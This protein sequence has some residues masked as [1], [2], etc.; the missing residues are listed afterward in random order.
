MLLAAM[1][2]AVFAHAAPAAASVGTNDYP[3]ANQTKDSALSPL[4][5]Y[6]RECTDYAAWE[7][8]E[9]MGGDTTHILFKWANIESGGSGNA[10]NWK[11]GA[12]N[13]YGANSVNATP[14]VG[15]VAW[16]NSGDWT[17]DSAGHVAIV[18]QVDYNTNG[19]VKDIVVADYNGDNQGNYGSHTINASGSPGYLVWPNNFLHIADVSGGGSTLPPAHAVPAASAYGTDFYVVA[20]GQDGTMYRNYWN[21]SSWSG[22]AGIAPNDVYNT[23][24]VVASAGGL[25]WVIGRG[26]DGNLYANNWNG[27]SWSGFGDIAPGNVFTHD[28]VAAAYGSGLMVVARGQDGTMYRNYWNGTSWSGSASIAPNNVFD[29][30]PVV[31]TAG[32][33]FWVVA[34]G[35]DGNIYANAWNG[36]SWTG[37]MNTA[38]GHV[39]DDSPVA[40]AYGSGT[41]IVARGQDGNL[42]TN[43]WNGSSWGGFVDIAPGNVFP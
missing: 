34:R 42:Y 39:F 41:Y 26:L 7:I 40:A 12:I 35:Q 33:L 38:P 2:G 37:F 15:S 28:P 10:V 1:L 4:G 6:Y 16:W 22:S 23:S 21:G 8:N 36:S 32:G 25:F 19:S 9:Q 30:D 14:A 29:A 13:N 27:T 31:T 18:S 17:G 20:R 11:Q 43:Y 5:F 24:P 3:W